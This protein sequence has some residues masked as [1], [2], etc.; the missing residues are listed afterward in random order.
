MADAVTVFC[1]NVA[2]SDAWATAVCNAIRPDDQAVLDRLDPAM[3]DGVL[4]IM[5]EKT[6]SWGLL[7]PLVPAQVDEQLISAGDR[8]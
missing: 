6:V 1:R 4:A 7:P 5:G 8:L 3:V 2:L